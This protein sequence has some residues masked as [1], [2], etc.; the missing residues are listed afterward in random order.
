MYTPFTS[1]L[2]TILLHEAYDYFYDSH[3]ITKLSKFT[4][5][6]QTN[7]DLDQGPY[8]KFNLSIV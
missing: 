3:Y 6:I 2:Y 5:S 4:I 7:K 8:S 1:F